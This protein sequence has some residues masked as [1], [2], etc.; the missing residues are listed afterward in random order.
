M[1]VEIGMG[2]I[3][4]GTYETKPAMVNNFHV[5]AKRLFPLNSLFS[6]Y[7]KLG[8]GVSLGHGNSMGDDGMSMMI[9]PMS[10]GPY[11]GAGVR[12]N[13]TKH[14]AMYVEDSG[15]VAVAGGSFGS[16][17]QGTLGLEFTM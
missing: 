9:T 5:A 10:E 6:L 7:G 1:G 12:L 14:F 4:N 15:I 16:V 11:Y 2:M 13:L 17:N 8:A 3:T